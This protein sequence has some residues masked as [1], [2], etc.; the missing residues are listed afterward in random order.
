MPTAAPAAIVK[1]SG[2]NGGGMLENTRLMTPVLVAALVATSLEAQ[3]APAPN[4]DHHAHLLS[5]AT[6]EIMRRTWHD[7]TPL[8][9]SD[10]IAV[11]DSARV[12]RAAVL[13]VAYMR[14][15]PGVEQIPRGSDE[16]ENVRRENDWVVQ[17]VAPYA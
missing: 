12:R 9:A 6:A 3:H 17:Q 4:A 15:M 8:A 5:P 1:H 13:S 7:A 16:Y 14:G 11:L 2:S 10:L